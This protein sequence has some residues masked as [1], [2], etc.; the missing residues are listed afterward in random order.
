MESAG[1]EQAPA[2]TAVVDVPR[3]YQRIVVPLDGTPFAEAALRP[4]AE[5][6]S[7]SGGSLHIAT[8]V[9]Q[10]S[11]DAVTVE[12]VPVEEAEPVRR[13]EQLRDYLSEVVGRVREEWE[14]DV[15]SRLVSDG[16]PVAALLSHIREV[17]ADLVIAATHSRSLVVR[18]LLGSAAVDLVRAAPCPV[19]LVPS[20]DPEPDPWDTPLQDEVT[21]V[22]AA[23]D[24]R[25]DPQDVALSHA[26]ACARLWDATLH[27][28]QVAL[29]RPLPAVEPESGAAVAATTEVPVDAVARAAAEARVERIARA[30]RDRG[31]DARGEVLH[32]GRASDAIAAFVERSQADLLV[33]GHHDRSLFER[34]W[35]GSESERLAHRV[36]SAGLLICPLPA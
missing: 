33:A 19:L 1:R 5:I 27:V 25:G 20:A 22:V 29:E 21:S 13:S 26:I 15:S 17:D 30:L 11:S 3:R 10:G 16:A 24:P 14:C 4:A 32:G 2:E 31:I 35:F 9:A 12:P 18:A 6:A 8:A 34:L 7:R 23:V 36:R 28:V